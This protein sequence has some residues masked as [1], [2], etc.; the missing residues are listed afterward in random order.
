MAL[1]SY[2]YVVLSSSFSSRKSQRFPATTLG[3]GTVGDT[4]CAI[5]GDPT[6][7][8]A[9]INEPEWLASWEWLKSG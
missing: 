3:A 8:G 1:T 5:R 6:M 4:S 7:V 9:T 2:G